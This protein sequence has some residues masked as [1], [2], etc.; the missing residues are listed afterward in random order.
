MNRGER[1]VQFKRLLPHLPFE[2]MMHPNEYDKCEYDKMTS[3]CLHRP[4]HDIT[5]ISYHLNY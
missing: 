1:T 4:Y 2:C 5:I 3:F